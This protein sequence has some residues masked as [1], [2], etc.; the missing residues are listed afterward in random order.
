LFTLLTDETKYMPVGADMN[1]PTVQAV[2]VL[3]V[4][5]IVALTVAYFLDR[6]KSTATFENGYSSGR[7]CRYILRIVHVAKSVPS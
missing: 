3:I 1:T 7:R 5:A 4:L 6:L 2:I